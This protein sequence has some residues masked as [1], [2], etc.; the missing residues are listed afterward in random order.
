MILSL[1]SVATAVYLG[2]YWDSF[3]ACAEPIHFWLVGSCIG[4]IA[5]EV[6]FLLYIKAFRV[7]RGCAD[8]IS[9]FVPFFLGPVIAAWGGFGAYWFG[10]ITENDDYCLSNKVVEAFIVLWL[11]L[12]LIMIPVSLILLGVGLK[13]LFTQLQRRARQQQITKAG[14]EL[15]LDHDALYDEWSTRSK[16][17]GFAIPELEDIPEHELTA[18]DLQEKDIW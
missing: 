16:D 9:K 14:G 13:D 15:L 11:I 2:I 7:K 4:A 5:F 3:N 10:R 1:A 8:F 6:C 17:M 18:Q 12:C